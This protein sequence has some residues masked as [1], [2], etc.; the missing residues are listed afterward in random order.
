[1]DNRR[2]QYPRRPKRPPFE[3][4][5]Q[6][7]D[8]SIDWVPT[9]TNP[10]DACFNI[11]A[12]SFVDI[13][14]E[15]ACEHETYVLEPDERVLVKVGFVLDL[16]PGWEAQIRTKQS[17]ALKNGLSVLNSP[18][19]VDCSYKEEVGIILVNNGE[20]DIELKSKDEIAQMVITKVPHVKLWHVPEI[21]NSI[22]DTKDN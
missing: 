4:K 22:K 15:D 7:T 1:M 19:T 17:L 5:I 10:T 8:G 16:T 18:G 21:S 3:V 6:T 11:K 2:K 12:K 14:V 13:Y 20:Q 9:K